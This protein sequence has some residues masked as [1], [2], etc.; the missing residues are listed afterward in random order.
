M[1]VQECPDKIRCLDYGKCEYCECHEAIEKL[2][3]ERDSAR[4]EICHLMTCEWEDLDFEFSE[5]EYSKERGWSYL[6]EKE[7]QE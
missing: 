4:K 5:K 1:K 2:I 6:F 3:K 7:E